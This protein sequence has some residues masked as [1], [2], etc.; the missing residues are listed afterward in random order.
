MDKTLYA[1]FGLKHSLFLVFS[2]YN[3]HDQRGASPISC[4]QYSNEN[5]EA[6]GL[7]DSKCMHP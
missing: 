5:S 1:T 7:L 2:Y 6:P 4:E 3:E